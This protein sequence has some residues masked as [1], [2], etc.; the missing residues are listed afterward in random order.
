MPLALTP[1]EARDVPA[2]FDPQFY[3]QSFSPIPG[4]TG[5]VRTTVADLDGNGSVDT[6]YVAG[7]GGSARV[8]VYSG[9]RPGEP[10]VTSGTTGVL[11]VPGE[12]DVVADFIVFEDGFRGGADVT[13][14]NV[15]G[16]P[17]CLVFVPGEG[18]GPRVRVLSL[19]GSTD[20]SFFAFDD[21]DYRGGLLVERTTFDPN[22]PAGPHDPGVH[23]IVLPR[24]GGG[25]RAAVYD[26]DGTEL[27]SF[28][29]GP[30]DDRRAYAFVATDVAVDRLKDVRGVAVRTPDNTVRLFDWAGT[31]YDP[32]QFAD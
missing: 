5:E 14:V 7:P 11:K 28:L 10:L 17:D 12:G 21:P 16:G 2:A 27:A 8:V 22:V 15:P 24:E 20:A 25:P 30:A 32:D 3:D 4:W 6:A 19:D 31:E 18:G 26:R 23:L 29:V 1:L 9:G 13:S